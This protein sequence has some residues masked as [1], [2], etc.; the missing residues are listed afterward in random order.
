MVRKP[1][2]SSPENQWNRLARDLIY[3]AKQ[4]LLYAGI[5]IPERKEKGSAVDYGDV[6]ERMT[7]GTGAGAIHDPTTR[8][9]HFEPDYIQ[10]IIDFQTRFEFPVFDKSFGPGGIAGYIQD[11]SGVGDDIEL[12]NPSLN[13]IIRQAMIA[14]DKVMPFAFVSARQL[15]QFEV[16]QFGVMTNIYEGP[17]Y[18]NVSTQAGVDEAV[19]HREKGRYIITTHSI[20]DSPL[21]LS[22]KDKVDIFVQCVE[23]GLPVYLTTMPFSGQNGPMTPYG[24]ALLA[25][26]EF[27]AGMA[28]A[29]AVNPKVTIING[30]YPTM[31]TAGRNPELKM[32]SVTH[33]LVNYL[34]S[35]TSRLLDIPS[36][37]SGCTIEG[38]VHRDEIL[39]TDFQTVRAMLIWEDL[40]EGWHMLRHTYG[41]LADLANF[42]FEKAKDDIA[43]MH[44][45]QSLDDEGIT[46]VLANNIRL[47]MDF[48]KAEAIYK[49]PTNM[50]KRESG[51]VVW[52]IVD[53]VN[54]FRGDFGR[55]DHT[56]TNIPSEWF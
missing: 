17:I 20:F 8:R 42:S 46:A 56:L 2:Q 28:I 18:L 26:S 29:Y 33:N 39:G 38:T 10:K 13:H 11:G 53:T 12:K 50:F 36:I 15:A 43:A 55:H 27:L 9:V 25:F 45:I 32:G 35:Y 21:T 52:V 6:V 5:T 51:D 7:R 44:H 41:F 40:F 16:E 37:Q 48:R 4:V 24:I 14:K 3:D 23:R 30:A 49:K 22:Y 34:V 47:N 1:Q 31:C 54:N 19:K